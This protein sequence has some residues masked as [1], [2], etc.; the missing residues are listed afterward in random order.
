MLLASLSL[1]PLLLA[2]EPDCVT[3]ERVGEAPLTL[4]PAIAG[5]DTLAQVCTFGS[6]GG[7]CEVT[8]SGPAGEVAWLESSW[9]SAMLDVTPVPEALRAL[10]QAERLAI[11]ARLHGRACASPDPSLRRLL[12]PDAPLVWLTGPVAP[13][14]VYALEVERDGAL[15]W[16]LYKGHVQAGLLSDSDWPQPLVEGGPVQVLRYAHAVVLVSE[17]GQRHAWAWVAPGGA[18]PY[19]Q[20]K[21]RFPSRLEGRLEGEV[22]VLSV[23]G[24]ERRIPLTSP[25]P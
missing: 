9:H 14:E 21:L 13:P 6:G 23:S 20:S 8:L 12:E 25:S 18:E 16:L 1:S 3:A 5:Y 2:A 17:D 19:P 15:L 22:L 24:V 11:A 10:P 4:S 7:G